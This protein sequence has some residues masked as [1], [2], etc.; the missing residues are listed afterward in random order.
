MVYDFDGDGRAEVMCKTADGTRSGTNQVIGSSTADHRNSSGYI[1]AGPEFLT[2]FNGQTGAV[3]A[4]TNYVPARGNVGDW[5]DTYGNRVD[6]FLAGVAYLDGQ[7]PSAIFSRG[8]YTRAVIAA[9]DFRNGQL[10]QRWVFDSN[11][12]GNSAYAGQGNHNLSIADVD[13]DGRHEVIFG[14]ATIDDNGARMYTSGLGHGDAL[15]VGDFIPSRAGLEIWDIHESSNQPGAD[16]RDA[17][18]GA[19][20]FATPNNN[21][22]EGPGRG[23]A[24]DIWSGNE[25]AE[26]WGAGPNMTFLRNAS[27]GNIGRNPGSANHLA[28]WDAD[29]VRELVDGNHVDKYGTGGDTRLL[30]ADGT[31]TSNGTKSNPA[32]SGDLLGDWREEVVWRT[33]NNGALRIYTTTNVASNRIYTLLHDPQYRVAIAWQNTA[34]NQPPHPGFFIGANMPTPPTPNI[35]LV[36]G[37]P[38]DPQPGTP[39]YQFETA[40]LGGGTVSESTNSGFIGSGYANF[41]ATGGFAQVNNAD[42]RGGGSHAIR[43]RY[44]LGTTASRTGRVLVNGVAQNITFNPTGA[45]T[46]WATQNVT[47]TLNTG[48]VNTIRFES[49]GQDLANL[50]QVEIL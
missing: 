17:R 32:L 21:G 20:I 47:F 46:T 5:G 3:L 23:V 7:R 36:G 37:T 2:V 31:T 44:A 33:T 26:Y 14:A 50:D 43:I 9:W 28:W 41:S 4:T 24:A 25:G 42:G 19:R 40:S 15:H 1:L 48:T 35:T 49:N 45:W 29:T 8:Y 27:G 12:S 16:L 30:T 11:G 39:T 13:Q 38:P 18:T 6:R 10:T 34:Y 22:V